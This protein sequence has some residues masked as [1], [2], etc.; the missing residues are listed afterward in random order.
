MNT[1]KYKKAQ[2]VIIG[3][4]I[5]GLSCLNFFLIRGIIPKVIDTRLRPPAIN[6]LPSF[7][8]FC[9]G[10][11]CDEWILH[12]DLIVVSPGVRLDDPV[13]IEARRMGI[14]IIGDIELFVREITVPIIAITG[15]NG[16]STVTQLVGNMARYAGWKVGIVGNI[17]IPALTLLNNNYQL[18]ILEISSFQ[19]DV[20]YSLCAAA[21]TILN[22][23]EDHMDR[24]AAGIVDYSSSKNRIYNNA[25]T[26]VINFLDPLTYPVSCN[27]GRLVSFGVD[28]NSADY[29]IEYC[30]GKAWI[31]IYGEYILDCF[32]L[33]INCHINYYANIL[34]ALALSDSVN[35]PRMAS[36]QSLRYFSGLSHR[37]QLIY[38]N[39][40]VKWINDSKATNVAATKIA[41]NA[42]L[43]ILASGDLHLLLGGDGKLAN[44]FELT[45]LITKYEIHLYC[46]G[47]DG[48]FLTKSGS[49]NIFLTNDIIDA[50]NIIC[51]RVRRK[52]IVLLSP[53]CSS[54]DQFLS[55][56]YRGELFTYLSRRLG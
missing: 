26:C 56:K 38:T 5:T 16:K 19:L 44:F 21:A 47:K 34:S 15:S 6:Q 37:F 49:K 54:L 43:S 28:S 29:R 20:T 39:R 46:F 53:A 9:F 45:A 12:A 7:I 51:R 42:A 22:V 27:Y 55:F 33:H 8:E 3:L 13:L 17:G 11:L 1:T 4:G 30:K 52:D 31:V 23:S 25:I 36:L 18:Y 14:E 2:V 35:I 40:N 10:R 41:I 32:E 48:F 24:Y 50:M